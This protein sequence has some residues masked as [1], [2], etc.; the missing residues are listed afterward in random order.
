MDWDRV[1]RSDEFQALAG[2]RRRVVAPLLALF[3]VWYGGFL[4]LA[5]YARG[6]MA[7][8]IYRG[9]TVAY[10]AALSLVLM[11]WLIAFLY[12]RA[13]RRTIDPHIDRVNL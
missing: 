9:F 8:T 10:A 6:F 4:V 5:A 12:L 3:V 1:E 2:A 13:A 11:T 7:E